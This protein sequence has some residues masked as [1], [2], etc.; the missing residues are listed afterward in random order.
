MTPELRFQIVPVE[1][2]WSQTK[3]FSEFRLKIPHCTIVAIPVIILKENSRDE[4]DE[5]LT[6]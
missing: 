1:F 4:L 6:D 2:Y 3:R 5:E